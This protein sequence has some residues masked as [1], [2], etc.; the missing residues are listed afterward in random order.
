[1]A[2]GTWQDVFGISDSG[3]VLSRGVKKLKTRSVPGYLA[4]SVT[5][6]SAPP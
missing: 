6:S 3:V 4:L 2:D 5:S 1:M